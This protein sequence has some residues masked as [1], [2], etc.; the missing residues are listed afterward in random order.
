M[1]AKASEKHYAA[2]ESDAGGFMPRGFGVSKEKLERVRAW[3]PLLLP[4][5]IERFS[6]GGGG[7]DIQPLAPLG[8]V[9]F[10]LRPDGQRYFDYH[11]S[12]NDTIDKVHPRELEFGA[13]AMAALAWLISEE[14]L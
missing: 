14:G 9:L 4:F 7:A 3:E 6:E 12:R 8:T 10:G 5:G 11:H 1:A 13:A 2:C